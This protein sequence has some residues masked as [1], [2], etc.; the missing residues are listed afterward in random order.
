MKEEEIIWYEENWN[1]HKTGRKAVTH[2]RVWKLTNNIWNEP[3]EGGMSNMSFRNC[4]C[5]KKKRKTHYLIKPVKVEK[6]RKPKEREH[7]R[8]KKP[9]HSCSYR[10]FIWNRYIKQ[11][12]Y[13]SYSW[14]KFYS[15]LGFMENIQIN[16]I[17]VWKE[18]WP[19]AYFGSNG[20][21]QYKVRNKSY[22]NWDDRES[23]Y[24][25]YQ[26]IGDDWDCWG[27]KNLDIWEFLK[28]YRQ[29]VA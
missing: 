25:E 21:K 15:A 4:R 13:A 5:W 11:K 22:S 6:T 18:G 7:W 1:R 3:Y 20:R 23:L 8:Y 24:I 12:R 10:S 9:Y 29:K 26:E 2:G 27:Y 19:S 14:D 17:L 28:H 16:D